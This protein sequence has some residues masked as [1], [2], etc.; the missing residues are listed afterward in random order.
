ML[1]ENTMLFYVSDLASVDSG[2]VERS[3]K[4]IPRGYRGMNV[5]QQ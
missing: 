5:M 1:C 4:P 2:M 3:L